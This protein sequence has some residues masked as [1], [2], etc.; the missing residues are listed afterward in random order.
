MYYYNIDINT[1]NSNIDQLIEIFPNQMIYN[2]DL[3]INPLG[4]I[5]GYND[6]VY[7]KHVLETN[8][9]VEFPLS[10]IASNLTL[11]DTVDFSLPDEAETGRIIDGTLFL[12]ANNGFPFDA[13]IELKLYDENGGYIQSIQVND[14]I[15]AAPVNANL[16]VSAKR[17]ST[18]SIPMNTN[19]VDNL[20]RAKKVVLNI[21]FTTQPQAQFLKI[22][23]EYAID[24]QLVGDFKYNL[25]L[26]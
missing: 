9:K 1:G 11:Q 4:N 8:L 12:F 24:I 20:Y 21:A 5:S 2:I 22:Y 18:L 6:F 10:L 14:Y 26:K 23:E 16:R 7:K 17:E 15:K 19:D 25:S 3:I 13:V